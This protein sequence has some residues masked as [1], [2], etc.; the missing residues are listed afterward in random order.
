MGV[1][2]PTGWIV[3]LLPCRGLPLPP[4][5]MVPWPMPWVTA[6]SL[7]FERS[8]SVRAAFVHCGLLLAVELCDSP[9]CKLEPI[10]DAG[11]LQGVKLVTLAVPGPLSAE[12]ES[13]GCIR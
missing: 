8:R 12:E 4:A 5:Y 2:A 9:R 7:S 6:C 1:L 13:V 3:T 10:A 11:V